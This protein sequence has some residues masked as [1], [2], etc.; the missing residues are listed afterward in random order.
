MKRM[1]RN[2]S[3]DTL[4]SIPWKIY[5]ILWLIEE[6]DDV[7]MIFLINKENEMI[8]IN[9]MK[10]PMALEGKYIWKWYQYENNKLLYYERRIEEKLIED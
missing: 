6:I 7:I 10:W 8:Y 2:D 1:K 4:F 3:D 5:L 9:N